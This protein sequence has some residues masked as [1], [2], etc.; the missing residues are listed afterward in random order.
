MEEE[1]CNQSKKGDLG[2]SLCSDFGRC[3]KNLGREK[4][5]ILE[6]KRSCDGSV[7]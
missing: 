7:Q 5:V 6:T 3:L 4:L 2:D 1:D